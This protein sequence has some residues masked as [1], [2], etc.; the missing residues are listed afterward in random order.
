MTSHA[1]DIRTKITESRRIVIK[2]GSSSLAHEETGALDLVKLELLV[3]EICDLRNRGKDVILV[4]S[5][6]VMVGRTTLG[7]TA[8]G[9]SISEKQACASVGQAKLMMIYQKLFSEYGQICSQVLLTKSTMLDDLQRYN[10]RNTFQELLSLGVVPIVNEND[11][12]ATHELDSLSVFGD[13]DRLSAVVAAL[14]EADLL[15]LLSDIDGLYTD[16][17][18][19]NGDAEFIRLVEKLDDRLM[20]MGK[21][22][23]GSEAGTGGMATKLSAAEIAVN[24][25]CGMVI[26]S[27]SDFHVIHRILQ[28][29]PVGTLF[30]AQERDE[31]Y[32]HDLLEKIL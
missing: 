10:A 22:S 21:S 6:A 2:I 9:D 8:H 30:T 3:R 17:P 19:K 23:T 15:I 1:Q 24:A 32:V 11:T 31:F 18:R 27:G 4:S 20:Q 12:I 7:L 16:D 25:G 28:G 26:A 13:N 14:V 29:D 5:G